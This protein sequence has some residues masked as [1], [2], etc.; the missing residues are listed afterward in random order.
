MKQRSGRHVGIAKAPTGVSGLDEITGGGLP[1][2]RPTLICGGAGSGKTLIGMSIILNGVVKFGEPG[3]IMTFEE[4]VEELTQNVRSLGLD[5][6][7]LMA[8]DKLAIDYV[9][10]DRSEI[11]ET[12]EY[13][14]EALFVRIEHAVNSVRAKRVMLDTVESLFGSL[15]S[16]SVLRAELRRLF[17]WL[18]DR[19]LTTIITA[20][21]GAGTLTRHGLEEYVSDAVIMLDHRVQEQIST[22]RLRVV[23]YRG[24]AH[25]TNEY[26]FLISER[27]VSVEPITAVGLQHQASRQRISSGIPQL[28]EMLGGKGY[29]AGSSILI[30]GTAGTGKTSM[31]AHFAHATARRG[32][33]CL[34]FVFEESASQITRNMASIGIGFDAQVRSGRLRLHAARPTHFGLEEHLAAMRRLIDEYRPAAVVVD[35]LSNLLSAGDPR[36]VNVMLLRLV[37]LLKSRGMTA[38]FT[39]LT[40]AGMAED[41]T[42]LGVSSLMDTWVLLSMGEVEG[43]RRRYLYILKSRGMAHSQQRREYTLSTHGVRLLDFRPP[44]AAASVS[45]NGNPQGRSAVATARRARR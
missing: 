8:K 28:D 26:P 19:S 10:I 9:H 35:P 44:A 27:G 13:D 33:R 2:G 18:K 29:F 16:E 31:A 36:E 37:D 32:E 11:E 41:Q 14:L 5:V 25:G 22:R 21:R 40:P 34:Y 7:D 38:V 42:E 39:S 23:K 15:P 43:E 12:G 30:T 6:D 4:N 24:S 3:V 17:R 1:A 20:E 45:A